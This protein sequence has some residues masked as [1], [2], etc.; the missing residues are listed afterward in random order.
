MAETT[1]TSPP[2]GGR[3]TSPKKATATAACGT[4]IEYYD[5]S[6]FGYVA[7]TIATVFFPSNDPTMGLLNT[8]LVFGSAFLMRPLGSIFFGRL[9]DRSGRRASLLGSIGLMI[10]AVGLTGML[11]GYAQIGIW[12]PIVLIVLRMLQGFSAGGEIGG[13]SSYIREW[14]PAHRRPLYVSFVPSLGVLG[15]GLAAGMAALT[16]TLVPEGAMVSWGWRIPFLLAIPMGIL[17]L[18]M[19]LRVEDSPEF[20][21][22]SAENRTPSTPF[23][24]LF[25]QYR[26]RL[27]KVMGISLV[28]NVG[29]YVGTVF[30]AVY[31]S[32]ILG[33]SKSEASTI[34]LIAVL[35]AA[36]FIPVA[37]LLGNRI[38]ARRLL[39]ISYSAYVVL[40]IPSF[41]L[42]NRG[43]VG[44]AIAGLL[45]GMVPYA[46]CQAA[47]YSSMPEFF[48]VQVRHS[49]IAFGHTIGAALAGAGG[50]YL[51]TLLIDKTGNTMIPAYMLV[52]FGA[53]GLVL[54]GGLVRHNTDSETHLYR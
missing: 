13:A 5:F 43:S 39:L 36:A 1:T 34:V 44:L 38:G 54:V 46:L 52:L 28:Q 8:L 35:V 51:A 50:P 48:P 18:V 25:T 24:T 26:T 53:F 14:A 33:Y 12:A 6:V 3:V 29:T 4:L 37:G 27:L 30:V 15:K 21:A 23:K 9:G 42:M 32:S 22:A 45:I 40:T 31:F 49:G 10:V 41:V 16:A 20:T 19:R 2:S 47:T 11:P 17:V 7:A